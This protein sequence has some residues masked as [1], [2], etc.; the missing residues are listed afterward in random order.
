MVVEVP[1]KT[2]KGVLYGQVVDAWQ[3]TIAD[4]GPSGLVKGAGGKYLFLPPGYQGTVPTGYF[5][6]QSS[7]YRIMVA[8][9]SIPL[10]ARPML[11]P[12]HI[13]RH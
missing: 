9:R 7:S 3:V 6:I 2:A 11:T 8:L 13:A 1:V 10:A 4:I 12:W 5:P